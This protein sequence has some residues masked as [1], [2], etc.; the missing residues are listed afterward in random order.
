MVLDRQSQ[1][2]KRPAEEDN[3]DASIQASKLSQGTQPR[4]RKMQYRHVRDSPPAFKAAGS[5]AER[6]ELAAT[7][8]ATLWDLVFCATTME[9]RA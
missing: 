3:D 8:D 4:Q 2:G 6:R 1:L 9:R 7:W 5:A